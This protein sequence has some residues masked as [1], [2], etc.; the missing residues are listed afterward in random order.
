MTRKV[1]LASEKISVTRTRRRRSLA[2]RGFSVS[3]LSRHAEY[4]LTTMTPRLVVA[5]NVRVVTVHSQRE[6]PSN[7][8][9]NTYPAVACFEKHHQK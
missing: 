3:E 2:M 4:R 8:R 5:H 1:T 6:R 9:F 7:A